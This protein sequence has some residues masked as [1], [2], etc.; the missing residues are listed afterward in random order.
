VHAPRRSADRSRR[1]GTPR[2]GARGGRIA[3]PHMRSI[4]SLL[5]PDLHGFGEVAVVGVEE[6]GFVAVEVGDFDAA[7]FDFGEGPVAAVDGV[8]LGAADGAGAVA[9]FAAV[10][11]VSVAGVEGVQDAAAESGGVGAGVICAGV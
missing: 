4:R 5:L 2:T 7:A 10:A 6:D 9:A 11:A 1:P 3:F 8:P